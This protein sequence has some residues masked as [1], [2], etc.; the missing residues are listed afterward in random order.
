MAKLCNL[1]SV[2]ERA[3]IPSPKSSTRGSPSTHG[4]SP[5]S[6]RK[7]PRLVEKRN[8]MRRASR[9]SPRPK[10]LIVSYNLRHLTTRTA[11]PTT[12]R[13]VSNGITPEIALQDCTHRTICKCENGL[14]ESPLTGLMCQR[15]L[16]SSGSESPF[17]GFSPAVAKQAFAQL[18]R[19]CGP[20]SSPLTK[21]P[22]SIGDQV[23]RSR[24]RGRSE[25]DDVCVSNVI[26]PDSK[27]R[28]VAA[29]R[30][31]RGHQ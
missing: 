7:S 2:T 12:R 3:G 21:T 4:T 31:P 9:S 18:L 6:P 19:G 10:R 23:Q 26:S 13:P 27:R 25:G 22:L 5:I 14:P 20:A 8:R 15:L 28:R 29:R 30:S 17:L 16:E 11:T 1:D 24:K